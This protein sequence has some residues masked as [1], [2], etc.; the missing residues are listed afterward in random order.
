MVKFPRMYRTVTTTPGRPESPIDMIQVNEA[1]KA[2]LEQRAMEVH[3]KKVYEEHKRQE[4]LKA[5]QESLFASQRLPTLKNKS[6]NECTNGL[7]DKFF[8]LAFNSI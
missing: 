7:G 4:F 6:I 3:N 2:I 1:S 5:Q 8:T